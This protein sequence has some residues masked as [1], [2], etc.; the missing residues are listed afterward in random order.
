MDKIQTRWTRERRR[1]VL[2]SQDDNWVKLGLDLC[3]SSFDVS[4]RG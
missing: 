1:V 2:L 3:C 4:F